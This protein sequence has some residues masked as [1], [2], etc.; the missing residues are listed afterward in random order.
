M[1]V[2]MVTED[3]KVLRTERG[4]DRKPAGE[5]GSRPLAAMEATRPAS[6]GR[7]EGKRGQAGTGTR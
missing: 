2:V 7:V 5:V 3:E 4:R 6:E 1:N